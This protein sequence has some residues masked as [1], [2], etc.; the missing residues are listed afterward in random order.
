A[1]QV[2]RSL[3]T[4]LRQ[5]AETPEELAQWELILTL[6]DEWDRQSV[7]AMD[8]VRAGSLVEGQAVWESAVLPLRIRLRSEVSEHLERIHAASES[9]GAEAVAAADRMRG[10]LLF[11]GL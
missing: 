6:L 3:L 7:V 2:S 8:A 11:G 10:T 9:A 1:V 5:N 4:Q